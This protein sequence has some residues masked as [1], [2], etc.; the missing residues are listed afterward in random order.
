MGDF[1]KP[2]VNLFTDFSWRSLVDI[3]VVA[4]LIYR[5]LILIR[6]QRAW[7]VVGGVMAFMV[8]LFL[9]DR[10]QLST[11]HWMLD[12]AT[13]LAPVSLVILLLPELRQALEGFGKLGHWTQKLVGADDVQISAQAQTVEEIVAAAAEMSNS[14]TGALMILERATQLDDIVSNGMQL[15]AKVSS[16]LLVSIF[17]EGNPLHDGAVIIRGDKIIAGACRLPLSE[18]PL[19]SPHM[20]M[21]HRAGVGVTE[22]FDCVAIIVSEERGTMGISVDGE[23]QALHNQGE[24]RDALNREWRGVGGDHRRPNRP[25]IFRRRVK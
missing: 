22:M 2:L 5:L 13:V 20:H 3:L 1:F 9:S 12:K 7:R 16:P 23:Y 25:R 14:R 17:F 18:S 4:Y 19:L 24:L 11:V 15:D 10:L 6:G 8:M 21:R